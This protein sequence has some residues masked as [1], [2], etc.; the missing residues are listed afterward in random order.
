MHGQQNVIYIYIYMR[1]LAIVS[2]GKP[3]AAERSTDC[4]VHLTWYSALCWLN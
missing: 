4:R 2:T 1:L 3:V